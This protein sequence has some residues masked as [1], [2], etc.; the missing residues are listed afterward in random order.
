MNRTALKNSSINAA[1]FHSMSKQL[2]EDISAVK[3]SHDNESEAKRI[4]YGNRTKKNGGTMKN[5]KT[6]AIFDIN[7]N[8][9]EENSHDNIDMM[10]SKRSTQCNVLESSLNISSEVQK[11]VSYLANYKTSCNECHSYC[12]VNISEVGSCKF[13]YTFALQNMVH[14]CH[15]SQS[16]DVSLLR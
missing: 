8:L 4:F 12:S 15:F 7:K 6:S 5:A 10:R 11:W 1:H 9:T 3:I 14:D 13:K 2:N 16:Y